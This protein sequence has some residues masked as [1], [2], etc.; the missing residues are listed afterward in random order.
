MNFLREYFIGEYL[1]SEQDVLKKASINLV[2]NITIVSVFSMIVFFM[3]Y[4]YKGFHYQLIKNVV[5]IAL[6][7]SILFYMKEK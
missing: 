7:T 5:I 2:F 6:F 1:R 4:V 3:V